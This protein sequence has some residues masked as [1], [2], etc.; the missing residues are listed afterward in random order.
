MLVADRREPVT[1]VVEKVCIV[2]D[3]VWAL[4]IVGRGVVCLE[5][6]V[7]ALAWRVWSCSFGSIVEIAIRVKPDIA[8]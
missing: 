6:V 7:V 4:R 3:P 1:L 5:V 2:A 8:V